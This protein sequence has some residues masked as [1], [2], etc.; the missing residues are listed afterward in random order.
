MVNYRNIKV[1]N[2]LVKDII[3]IIN[4]HKELGYR[5]YSEFIIEAIR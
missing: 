4:H 3:S 5:T 2:E 1:P